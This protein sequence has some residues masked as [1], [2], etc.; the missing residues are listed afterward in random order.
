VAVARLHEQ[1]F[2]LVEGHPLAGGYAVVA[3]R[4]CGFVYA[5]TAVTQQ[6][7]YRFYAD[8]SKSEDQKTS[9]GGGES[10]HDSARL[11]ETAAWIAQQLP[12]R[13]GRI[14]DIGCANGGLL[15]ALR[16]LGFRD[17]AGLDPSPACAANTRARGFEAHVGLLHSVPAELQP[18]DCVVL[19]HVLEHVQDVAGVLVRLR[20][21]L[22]PGGLAYVEV[23]DATRYDQFLYAP[24]QDFNTEHINHFSPTSLNNALRRAGFTRLAGG[25]KTL[26]I[27]PEMFYPAA[28]GMFRAEGSPNP[29]ADLEHD[30][31]LQPA[32]ASYIRASTVLMDRIDRHLAEALRGDDAV[33]IWGTGQLAMKVL[34]LESLRRVRLAACVDSNPI[35]H[36]R[37]MR[38]ARIVAPTEIPGEQFPIVITTLLHHHGIVK[39]IRERGI[40]N[41]IVLLDPSASA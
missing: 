32:I 19:S 4:A 8:L 21:L 6:D 10:A 13:E 37:R 41:R 22:R 5:D 14:L 36:G 7:Y 40:K 26:P 33:V 28:Y 38:E 27:G 29:A 35:Y 12:N 1:K 16:S 9:T 23:P 2:E 30:S 17:L 11:R 31:A 15:D 25:A 39:N 34:A 20:S 24:F 18:A 3:C